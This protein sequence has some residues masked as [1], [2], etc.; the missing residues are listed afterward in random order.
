MTSSPPHSP[1]PNT[2]TLGGM[3]SIRE[4][5]GHKHLAPNK[6]E[7]KGQGFPMR[8]VLTVKAQTAGAATGRE[9]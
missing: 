2:T 3:A 1:H 7:V 9:A 8:T 5:G 6:G 4:F